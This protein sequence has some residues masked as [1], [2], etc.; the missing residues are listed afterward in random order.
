MTISF[1]YSESISPAHRTVNFYFHQANTGF[2]LLGCYI[3]VSFLL[4]STAST[5]SCSIDADSGQ[6]CEMPQASQPVDSSSALS[7]V[8]AHSRSLYKP[9][10]HQLILMVTKKGSSPPPGSLYAQTLDSAYSFTSNL[11]GLP[12][13]ICINFLGLL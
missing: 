5:H 8:N 7:H 10:N 13:E 6:R 3:K 11:L 1:P 12:Q 2:L 9:D 4:L